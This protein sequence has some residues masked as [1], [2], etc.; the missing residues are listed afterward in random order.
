MS[1]IRQG[2]KRNIRA[3]RR[4]V[5]SDVSTGKRDTKGANGSNNGADKEIVGNKVDS[6]CLSQD[7]IELGEVVETEVLRSAEKKSTDENIEYSDASGFSGEDVSVVNNN[8]DTA[9]IVQENVVNNS[10]NVE[11]VVNDTVENKSTYVNVV[12]GNEAN[13]DNHLIYIAPRI[14]E[15]G[16]E[17]V[18]FDD[19][20]VQEGCAKWQ[21]TICGYFVG[22][23]MGFNELRYHIRR[24]WGKFG[25]KE[26]IVN[27]SGINLFKFKDIEGMQTVLSKGPW[28]VNNRPLFVLKWNPEM[29]MKKVEPAKLPVWVKLMN[30]PME[31]WSLK[32]ISALASSLGKPLMMDEMTARMCQNGTGRS[33]Y[34]RV[35]VEFEACK[36]MK[37]EIKIEY[38]DKEKK[39]KGTK[40]VD[41]L[42]D[43][44]PEGCTHC[45][46]FGHC[47]E[48]CNARP[49]TV[50]EIKEKAVEEERVK[51]LNEAKVAENNEGKHDNQ[52]NWQKQRK[53]G[54]NR[55]NN[56]KQEYRE[57]NVVTG[58][59]KNGAKTVENGTNVEKNDKGK[60]KVH[61]SG[62]K[63][64]FEALNG[65]V[66]TDDQELSIL[67]GRM[68]VDSFLNKKLQP[69]CLES[70][71]WTQDMIR[72]FKDQWELDRLKEKEDAQKNQEDVLENRNAI[73]QTMAAD[74]VMGMSKAVL[75]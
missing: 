66:E 16:I 26:L 25:F 72:Y 42:Y 41:V 55:W 51:C 14:N 63:N 69:S 58:K 39:V 74:N 49:R 2:L 4:Y 54:Q 59:E 70:S 73:A 15:D 18:L 48:K 43:W 1:S 45:K 5:D 61:E 50:D 19:E 27:E 40:M 6:V 67:K 53:Y 64:Q 3:P 7:N 34:A 12:K 71:T 23:N 36:I 24:M 22:Q 8:G 11:N 30:I 47:F 57:K 20:I 60:G 65:V 46:V 56:N 33:D 10:T 32:G 9:K 17:T 28:M 21:T 75:N 13:I 29:G 62:N 38:T 37:D 35:M 52:G 31:A 44:K 68:V